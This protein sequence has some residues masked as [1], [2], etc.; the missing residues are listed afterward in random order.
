MRKSP[1]QADSFKETLSKNEDLAAR[2]VAGREFTAAFGA[3]V[4]EYTASV[5]CCHTGSEAML[6]GT[7][8]AAGL[9]C[10]FHCL[11]LKAF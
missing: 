9:K 5:R 10:P 2:L 4:S 8:A 1:L 7:F 11:Y 6:I 3:A